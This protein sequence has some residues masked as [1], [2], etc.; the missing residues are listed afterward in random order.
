ME[1]NL[2]SPENL[3]IPYFKINAPLTI[4]FLTS[5]SK[6]PPK[7]QLQSGVKFLADIGIVDLIS[8]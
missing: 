2:I 4:D 6:K 8:W 1:T 7:L 3:I 5:N